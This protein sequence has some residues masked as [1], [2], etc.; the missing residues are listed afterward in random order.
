M[1]FRYC[2]ICNMPTK[3]QNVVCSVSHAMKLKQSRKRSISVR[4]STARAK[5][6]KYML[7]HKNT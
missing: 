3:D 7:T 1:A 2:L 5:V 6:V 4:C